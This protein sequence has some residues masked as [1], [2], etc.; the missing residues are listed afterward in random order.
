MLGKKRFSAC[1]VWE[2]PSVMVDCCGMWFTA[3]VGVDG[4]CSIT[5]CSVI[6][7]LLWS[8]WRAQWHQFRTCPAHDSF[9][10]WNFLNCLVRSLTR[11]PMSSY[12]NSTTLDQPAA[13]R[14]SHNKHRLPYLSRNFCLLITC[15]SRSP[16]YRFPDKSERYKKTFLTVPVKLRSQV[17]IEPHLSKRS[18][19]Y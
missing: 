3:V 13:S 9:F 6:S 19:T 15:S 5:S 17:S 2:R 12:L 16:R 4:M 11:S 18:S 14:P 7:F 10:V 8:K 1:H